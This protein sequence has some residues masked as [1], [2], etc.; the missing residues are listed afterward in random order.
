[1]RAPVSFQPL[2]GLTAA[3]KKLSF[4]HWSLSD[5]VQQPTSLMFKQKTDH[6]QKYSYVVFLILRQRRPS[7]LLR[8]LGLSNGRLYLA[9]H[10]GFV[11]DSNY[12]VIYENRVMPETLL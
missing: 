11:L 5:P 10:Q 4:Q 8:T 2:K 1:M 7:A 3:T 9:G 12:N 6:V